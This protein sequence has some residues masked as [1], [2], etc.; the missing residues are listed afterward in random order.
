[1]AEDED[2]K[3]AADEDQDDEE[4]EEKERAPSAHGLDS[5]HVQAQQIVDQYIQ[6][7]GN[8]TSTSDKSGS[9]APKHVPMTKQ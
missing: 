9:S 7:S 3:A 5:Q 2:T 8:V 6:K 1:M 4:D